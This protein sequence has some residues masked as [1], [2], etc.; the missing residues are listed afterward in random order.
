MSHSAFTQQPQCITALWL[1]AELAFVTMT[2]S[3]VWCKDVVIYIRLFTTKVAPNKEKE[4][5][6][7]QRRQRQ[8]K[9]QTK[10]KLN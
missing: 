1:Q 3:A 2:L 6:K 9:G 8:T 10:H 7:V 5:H 4:T